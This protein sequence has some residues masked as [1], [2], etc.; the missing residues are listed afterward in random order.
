MKKKITPSFSEIQA[1]VK[2]AVFKQYTCLLDQ[3]SFIKALSSS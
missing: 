2:F 1:N 3:C